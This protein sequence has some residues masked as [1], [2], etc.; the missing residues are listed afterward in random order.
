MHPISSPSEVPLLGC[1]FDV[2][3]FDSANMAGFFFKKK[4]FRRGLDQQQKYE[5]L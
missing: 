4:K 2:K 1:N 3:R 5:P